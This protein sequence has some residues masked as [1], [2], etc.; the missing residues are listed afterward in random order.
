MI[1]WILIIFDMILGT[2]VPVWRNSSCVAAYRF[3]PAP[4]VSPPPPS[5]SAAPQ[6]WYRP[7]SADYVQS[8]CPFPRPPSWKSWPP[9][10]IRSTNCKFYLGHCSTTFLNKKQ[11]FFYLKLRQQ[12]FSHRG[13]SR[14]IF[15]GLSSFEDLV[16]VHFLHSRTG[17]DMLLQSI[18]DKKG[19]NVQF[20]I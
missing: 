14:I 5:S 2:G 8:R 15:P 6:E 18:L 19:D 16:N 7:N 10:Q 13:G 20:C 3:L 17:N 4:S 11:I 1:S 9:A 12:F